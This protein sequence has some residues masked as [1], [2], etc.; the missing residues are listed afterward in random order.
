MQEYEILSILWDYI[1]QF[2]YQNQVRNDKG[3]L[4]IK[5]Q[6]HLQAC[7]I[8]K[9]L[10]GGLFQGRRETERVV[11]LFSQHELFH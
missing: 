7:C 4:Q 10:L 1:S 9:C 6:S 3:L 5:D 8:R 2:Q 11:F